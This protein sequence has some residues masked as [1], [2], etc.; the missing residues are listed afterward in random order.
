[1]LN[2][3]TPFHL[4]SGQKKN[5]SYWHLIASVQY[6]TWASY[7]EDPG[8][9]FEFETWLLCMTSCGFVQSL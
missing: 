3:Y 8:F 1:M 2:S 9:G 4:N 7:A 5:K 6:L